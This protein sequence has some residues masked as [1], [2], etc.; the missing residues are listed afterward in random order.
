MRREIQKLATRTKI[1][2]EKSEIPALDEVFFYWFLARE[3]ESNN[4]PRRQDDKINE[5]SFAAVGVL[6]DDGLQVL[7]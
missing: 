2:A 1:K 4:H 3:P 7:G 6:P 5:R